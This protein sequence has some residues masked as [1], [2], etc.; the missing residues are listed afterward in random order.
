MSIFRGLNAGQLDDPMRKFLAVVHFVADNFVDVVR[1]FFRQT[2][3]RRVLQEFK[4]K[5][6][7]ALFV[8]IV[9]RNL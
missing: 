4:V 2:H 3:A 5:L 7:R 1:E 9:F 6:N 8:R